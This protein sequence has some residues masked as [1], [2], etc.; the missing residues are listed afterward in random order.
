MNT[1]TNYTTID[2][3]IARYLAD[4]NDAEAI[5][6]LQREAE[7]S[8][9]SREYIRRQLEVWFSA[10]VAAGEPVFDSTAAYKRF[11][12]RVASA[13][14][15]VGKESGRGKR[16]RLMRRLG[17]AAAVALMAF[18]P[19]AGY[20]LAAD[21]LS[22][23]YSDITIAT[24]QGSTTEMRLPDGT[25]VWLNAGSH[26]TYS[27]AFGIKNRELHLVGEACFDVT[28]NERMPF[29]VNSRAAH[30]KVL[31]TK[32]N[33][34]DYPGDKDMSVDLI[35]GSVSLTGNK[36]GRNVRLAP[37]ERVTLNKA[38]GRMTR[39]TIDASQSA[40]WTRG[41]QFFDEVDIDRIA[42]TLER[43]YGV[44][45][46]VDKSLRGSRFYCAFNTNDYSLEEVLAVLGKTQHVKYRKTPNGCHLY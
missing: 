7:A 28:H 36:T 29:V 44:R 3:M 23:N 26:I 11:S 8:A 34:R 41:D 16:R 18:L 25:R 20:R 21:R 35:R 4:H 9:E 24:P 31:G 32:F 5:E 1:D 14:P 45:I 27:Q 22:A 46:S 40:T 15:A 19:W 17:V 30:L 10:G 6:A 38:T 42:A 43:A 33:Y 13:A 12:Q 39:Q 2:A 37:S